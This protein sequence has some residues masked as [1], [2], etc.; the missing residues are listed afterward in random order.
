MKKQR[1]CM[2]HL[3]RMSPFAKMG[4]SHSALLDPLLHLEFQVAH[5]IWIFSSSPLWFSSSIMDWAASTTPLLL[6]LTLVIQAF[7]T[8]MLDYCNMFYLRLPM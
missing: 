8:S 3:L 4:H 6:Y 7:I 1:H 2:H 5:R